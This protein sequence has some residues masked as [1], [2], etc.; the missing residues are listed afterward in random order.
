MA[1]YDVIGETYAQTRRSDPRIAG[2]LL[3]ILA[4]S[5]AHTIVDIGAGTGSYAHVLAEYGY[6]VLAIE[7]SAIMRIQAIAHPAIEWI[8]GA[9]D[10]LPLFE[11]TVDA[12]IVMLAFHHF[13]DSRQ[14]LREIHRVV[15]NGQIV[16]FTYDPAMISSFWLTEYFPSLIKD[17]E[18]T[19]LPIPKLIDEIQSIVDNSVNIVPFPLPDDLSDSFAAVGWARPELYLD[20]QI[21]DGISSFAKMDGDQLN[22]GLSL[23]RADLASGLWNQKYGY[24]RQQDQYD[25]GY[26]FIHSSGA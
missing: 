24:L 23:L 12:A 11:R 8:N 3:E 13:P 17:V 9:A 10:N 21:R 22:E 20:R 14:A 1:L 7:P 2:K 4:S 16:L 19:F 15:G 25:V 6:H 18:T 5:K 26:R